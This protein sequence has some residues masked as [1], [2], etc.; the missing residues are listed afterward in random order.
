MAADDKHSMQGKDS[1]VMAER[2]L[3]LAFSSRSL[4][5][6]CFASILVDPSFTMNALDFIGVHRR[7][8]AVNI[9]PSS[10]ST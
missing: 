2:A 10:D 4:R 8:S 7:P 1:K 9:A 3:R 6:S 5:L